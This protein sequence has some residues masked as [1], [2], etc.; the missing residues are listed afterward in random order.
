[1]RVANFYVDHSNKPGPA[2]DVYDTPL[3]QAGTP[4]ITGL[5]Y[6]SISPYVFP[7]EASGVGPPVVQLYALPA[8]EDPVANRADAVGVGGYQ[9]DGSH[10]QETI[11]LDSEGASGNGLGT[12]PL[13]GLSTSSF[14]EKGDDANGGKAPVAPPPTGGQ[15]E[16]LVSTHV[17]EDEN[18]SG[19]GGNQGYFFFIDDS[20]TPPINGDPNTKGLPEVFNSDGSPIKSAF[21]IFPTTSGSHDVSIVARGGGLEPTCQQLTPRQGKTTTTITAGQ[22][23]LVFIYGTSAADLHLALAPVQP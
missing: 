23:V 1:V 5:A 7:P 18:L 3:G 21:A 4:L 15:G 14:V 2:L 17:V 13:A 9:D 6:G 10:L 20:C 11:V 8:G 16:F 12:G 22:Q 19:P